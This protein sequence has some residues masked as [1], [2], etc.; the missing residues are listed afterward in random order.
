MDYP[1]C[2]SC[3]YPL[4]Y[5]ERRD[6]DECPSCGEAIPKEFRMPISVFMVDAQ[7]LADYLNQIEPFAVRFGCDA[8]RGLITLDMN[9]ARQ[10]A[11]WV[12]NYQ[13]RKVGN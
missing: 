3:E 10:L 7:M 1:P 8:D 12:E 13:E 6:F 4:C 11:L 9:M 5:M 2:P